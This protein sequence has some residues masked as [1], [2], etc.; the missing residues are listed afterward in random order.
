MRSFFESDE[1]CSRVEHVYFSQAKLGS[2]HCWS[3]C[4]YELIYKLD[5]SSDQIFPDRVVRLLPDSIYI[6]PACC[7]YN[8]VKVD[9]SG[10]VINVVFRLLDCPFEDQFY[11]ETIRLDAN[12][13]YRSQFKRL[14]NVWEK[15][16]PGY[17]FLAQ[18]ILS[19]ILSQL[20]ADRSRA[21]LNSEAYSRIKPAIDYIGANLTSEISAAQLSAL[22]EISGE[23]MRRLFRSYTGKNP[24]EYIRSKRLEAARELIYKSDLPIAD[25]AAKCGYD[26]PRYFSRLY[27]REYGVAPTYARKYTIG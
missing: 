10:S 22:C 7:E 21:Y 27:S 2:F 18:S 19:L 9:A 26:D 23:Y 4:H 16:N 8:D 15:K 24:V 25:I 13:R 12:N 1:Y 3:R 20:A 11:P 14:L 6:I 17:K 5:G